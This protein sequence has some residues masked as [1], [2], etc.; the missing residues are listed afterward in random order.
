MLAMELSSHSAT[1]A[2]LSCS[3]YSSASGPNSID[4][5]IATAP[6]WKIAM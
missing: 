4:S 5:G 3:R 6:S 1:T 2:S